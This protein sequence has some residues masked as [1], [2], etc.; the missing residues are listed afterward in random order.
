[1]KTMKVAL[2]ATAALAAVSVSARADDAAAIKAQLEALNARIAQLE[3]GPA[4][5]VGYS[6]LA[7]SEVDQFTLT[8][9][10]ASDVS[11]TSTANRI[12]VL[13]T[14]DAPAAA[15]ISWSAEIRAA[16]THRNNVQTTGLTGLTTT[17]ITP[18]PDGTGPL[19]NPPDIVNTNGTTYNND[20]TV[21]KARGRIRAQATTSTSV[22][23]VGID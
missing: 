7:L 23:D 17:I 20:E 13:P 10:K 1:M 16:L 6:L 15:S 3:A 21:I 8:G 11:A 19:P 14:A 22:G 4:L 2:L 18:D 12:S 9:E 5:P